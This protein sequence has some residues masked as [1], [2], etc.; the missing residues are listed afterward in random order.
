MTKREQQKQDTINKVKYLK[1]QGLNNTEI[2]RK[3]NISRVYVS[4]I[5]N[6]K[7]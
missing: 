4:N 1:Q 5:I 2:A 6:E 7:V 3:L